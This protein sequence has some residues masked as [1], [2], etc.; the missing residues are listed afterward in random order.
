[1]TAR[2]VERT[3]TIGE[4][5]ERVWRALID[6]DLLGRW[7]R[8]EVELDPRPGGP[9]RFRPD[10]GPSR[11]GRVAAVDVGR[12]LALDWWP[13]GLEAAATRVELTLEDDDAGTRL[14]VV[15][16]GFQA[17]LDAVAHDLGWGMAVA[18]APVALAG[19][20]VGAGTRV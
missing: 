16:S 17:P 6:A 18:D 9:A 14:S 15:E 20:R 2:R 19:M 3:I 1:V 11:T 4:Q 13:D 8:A 5:R 12:R 10:H 7:L